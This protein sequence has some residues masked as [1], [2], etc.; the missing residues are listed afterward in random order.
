MKKFFS[1]IVFA[2]I[3]GMFIASCG[4]GSVGKKLV[5]NEILGDLPNLV[6]QKHLTD[7]VRKAKTEAEES[8]AQRQ[9]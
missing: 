8:K 1:T 6:N 4:G 5:S 3:C 7:S 9:I 2:I